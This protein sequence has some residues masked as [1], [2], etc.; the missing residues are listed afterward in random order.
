MARQVLNHLKETSGD[1]Q[2]IDDVLEFD[3]HRRAFWNQVFDNIY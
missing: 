2:K 1:R 3:K